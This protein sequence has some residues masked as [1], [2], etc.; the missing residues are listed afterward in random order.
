[1]GPAVCFVASGAQLPWRPMTSILDQLTPLARMRFMW[2]MGARYEHI[3][4]VSHMR[5]YSS[6]LSHLIGEHPEVNGYVEQQVGYPT[7]MDLVGMRIR[8][9]E[10]TGGQMNGKYLFDKILHNRLRIGAEVAARSDVHLLLSIREPIAAVQSTVAMARKNHKPGWKGRVPKVAGYYRERMEGMVQM[11]RARKDGDI[12]FF[13]AE[14]AVDNTAGLLAAIQ[15]YLHLDTPFK[16]S[17]TPQK[18]TGVGLFGDPSDYI[19]SGQVVKKRADHSGI[20]IPDAIR[21]ELQTSYEDT[22]QRL[23]RLCRHTF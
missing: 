10:L 12:L 4:L 8:T 7:E 21:K 5:S 14:R 18:L 11:A 2:K 17:Y 1:M 6:L 13:Q 3:F 19:K 16:E 23:R 22:Q 20:E 9:Y 15:R